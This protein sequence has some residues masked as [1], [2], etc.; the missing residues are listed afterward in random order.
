MTA[1]E[2]KF[3]RAAL[4]ELFILGNITNLFTAAPADCK[5]TAA[6]NVV[7]PIPTPPNDTFDVSALITTPGNTSVVFIPIAPVVLTKILSDGSSLILNG[8]VLSGL[9]PIP[10]DVI[11]AV[12]V[13]AALR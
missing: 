2:I 10:I 6:V 7:T 9:V 5:S 3:L 1:P 8:L 12:Y 4:P 11:F 13:P